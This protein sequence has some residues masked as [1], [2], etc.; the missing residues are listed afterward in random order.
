MECRRKMSS[1]YL[2]GVV[3]G[4][5]PLGSHAIPVRMP[6]VTVTDAFVDVVS[7]FGPE[8]RAKSMH[9]EYGVLSCEMQS[10]GPSVKHFSKQVTCSR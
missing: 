4:P 6:N 3:S 1:F 9:G 10:V 2:D 7:E 5:E 8:V